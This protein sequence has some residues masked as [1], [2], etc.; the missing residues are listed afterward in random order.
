MG[1]ATHIW[2]VSA[3]ECRLE[4]SGRTTEM[5]QLDKGWKKARTPH[6]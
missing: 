6:S 4:G 5:F 2:T 1:Q 3:A